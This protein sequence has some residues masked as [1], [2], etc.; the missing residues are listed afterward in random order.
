V[1]SALAHT[2]DRARRRRLKAL[3]WDIDEFTYEEVKERP[4]IVVR[5]LR[6]A[7]GV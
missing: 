5:D 6:K 1:R 7:L 4:H 2:R 3:G